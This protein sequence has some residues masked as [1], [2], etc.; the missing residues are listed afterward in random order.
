MRNLLLILFSL[1]FFNSKA[2]DCKPYKI[3]SVS[4]INA[5]NFSET[6]VIGDIVEIVQEA[7]SSNGGIRVVKI[8]VFKN[9]KGEKIDELINLKLYVSSPSCGI[10]LKKGIRHLVYV[11]K[12]KD[13]GLMT[14][15]CTRTRVFTSYLFD[16]IILDKLVK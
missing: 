10:T 9:Y 16:P 13:K 3:D 4:I 7:S 5:L 6:V 2:C 12:D 15:I 8:K 11:Y 14:N 1:A